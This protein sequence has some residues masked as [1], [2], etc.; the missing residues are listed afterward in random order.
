MRRPS[1]DG[2]RI[3][4]SD[5]S[6]ASSECRSGSN[7]QVA[8]SLQSSLVPTTHVSSLSANV[9]SHVTGAQIVT[10]A[11]RESKVVYRIK[12][13]LADGTELFARRT[14]EDIQKLDSKIRQR[15]AELPALPAPVAFK[16]E[17]VIAAARGKEL[18][19]YL[20]GVV[21]IHRHL[22]AK[23]GNGLGLHEVV[24]G[25]SSVQESSAVQD[26]VPTSAANKYMPF[27]F[28]LPGGK[29]RGSSAD[30]GFASRPSRKNSI[31]NYAPLPA[32]ADD[33][34]NYGVVNANKQ[35]N[36]QVLPLPAA[37]QAFP[38]N[39]TSGGFAAKVTKRLERIANLDRSSARV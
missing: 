22:V 10:Y 34:Q 4:A 33:S 29:R 13:T 20:Q 5:S 16:E 31:Q 12:L 7:N 21:R 8:E 9:G 38:E 17:E 11:R 36:P 25:E 24:F 37:L 1:R 18:N 39:P 23:G 19:V 3:N 6:D 26:Q 28:G 35:G 27:G 32:M 30:S 15:Y 2:L 14:Y